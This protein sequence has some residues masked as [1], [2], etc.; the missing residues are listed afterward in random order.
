M[1]ESAVHAEIESSVA[2]VVSLPV[3]SVLGASLAARI[4]TV[5]VAIATRT[6]AAQRVFEVATAHEKYEASVV[7]VVC[8]SEEVAENLSALE[9]VMTLEAA[10]TFGDVAEGC[11]AEVL[12]ILMWSAVEI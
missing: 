3:V 1:D 4:K 2:A 11:G 6:Y 8:E 7:V 5:R 10:T 12:G 9:D